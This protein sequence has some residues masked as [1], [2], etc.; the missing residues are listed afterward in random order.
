MY[1][2]MAGGEYIGFNNAAYLSAH[3]AADRNRALSHYMREN[4]VCI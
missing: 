1:K 4:G 3:E 2:K